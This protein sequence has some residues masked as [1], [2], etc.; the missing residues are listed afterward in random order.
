VLFSD[1]ANFYMNG[2]VNKQNCR[3]W[4]RENPHWYIGSKHEGAEK[5]MVWFGACNLNNV[6]PFFFKSTVTGKVYLNMLG[7]EFMQL[8]GLGGKR[9]WFMQDGAPPHCTLPVR[10]WLD[11]PKRSSGMG[12]EIARFESHE[13]GCMGLLRVKSLFCKNCKLATS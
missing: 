3:Y 2:K 4:S 11:R 7:N 10:Q 6:G 5:L 12:P 1:E 9:D 13:F 8:D